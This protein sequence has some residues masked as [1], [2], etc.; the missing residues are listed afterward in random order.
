MGRVTARH[1]AQHLNAGTTVTRSETLA[2]EEPLEIRVNGR[3]IT[4]TM[5]TP[6]SDFELA[7]G[8]LLTEGVIGQRDDVVSVRYCRGTGPPGADAYN[9]VDV[10]LAPTVP[11]M[12]LDV[13]RNFYTT[14]SC[15]VCGKASL[16]AVRLVSRYRLHDI[17]ARVAADTLSAMPVQLRAA[18][19]VFAATGGLHAA[20]LFDVDGAMLVVREDIGRHNAVDKVIGW[21]LEHGRVP[22]GAAVLLV[23]GRASFELT[24]KAVMAGIPMLAAVSAPSSLAVELAEEA[25]LTLAAFLRRDSMNV[26]TRADRIDPPAGTIRRTADTTR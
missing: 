6:G 4:V 24:Q 2:V 8:F 23:S 17:P 7:Q 12:Q 1:P 22:P 9:V 5:R 3:P 15:G 16:D 11:A 25:G 14:T 21:A 19:K 18:Q 20:A 26:Y 10:D 13:T